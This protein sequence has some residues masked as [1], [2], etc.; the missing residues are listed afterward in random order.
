MEL[1][2][3][4]IKEQLEK[5]TIGAARC[6]VQVNSPRRLRQK[7]FVLNY[8][9]IKTVKDSNNNNNNNKLW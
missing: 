4:P 8:S 1:P 5:M 6:K 7:T 3:Q 9:N 2:N